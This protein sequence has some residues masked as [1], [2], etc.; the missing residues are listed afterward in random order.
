MFT[1]KNS[2][3]IDGVSIGQY[4]V[5]VKYEY[6]KLWSADSGRNLAGVQTGTLVGIFPKIILQFRKLTK[7]EMEIV[8]PLLDKANQSVTYY[9]PRKKQ[10]VTM[11]TYAG[12]YSFS[13]N[14]IINGSHKNGGFECSLIAVRKR[15]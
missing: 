9:D 12:D 5:S 13:D 8:V 15:A 10:N 14:T 3:M 2:L 4:L 1:G 7:A 6:P 11:T